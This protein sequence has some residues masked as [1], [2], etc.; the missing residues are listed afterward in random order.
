MSES[1]GIR[2][3]EVRDYLFYK[4]ITQIVLQ[5]RSGKVIPAIFLRNTFII[6][7]SLYPV[8]IDTPLDDSTTVVSVTNS[9]CHLFWEYGRICS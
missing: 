6:L 8:S 2:F 7:D 1:G 9:L 5:I 4:K 3:N